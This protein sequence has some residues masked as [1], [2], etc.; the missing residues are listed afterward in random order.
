MEYRGFKQ[1]AG[2]GCT[3]LNDYNDV[4]VVPSHR[5]IKV[6]LSTLYKM[7]TKV[8]KPLTDTCGNDEVTRTAQ[9]EG[10]TAYSD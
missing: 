6:Q 8:M 4:G 2:K 3:Y 1:T 10:V 5:R 7:T 9:M